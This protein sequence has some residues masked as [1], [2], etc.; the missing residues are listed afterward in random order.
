MEYIEPEIKENNPKKKYKKIILASCFGAVAV[1]GIALA[2]YFTIN[3][4]FLDYNNI[5]LFTYSY[6]YDEDNAGI[7]IDSIK[8][9]A[10]LPS[11]FRIPNKLNNRPVIEIAPEVFK[12][13]TELV[14][15]SF[16]SSLK[17]IGEQCFYGCENLESFNIP[18]NLES[19]GTEAF[20]N[21]KW[22]LDQE[23]GEVAIGSM[24]Y[25][26]KG[27]MDYPAY[28]IASDNV[29]STNGT[30]VDLRKY[31]NMSSGVFK[32][33]SNL[34]HVELPETFKEIYPSTFEGCEFLSEVVLHDGLEKIDSNAFYSC[35]NLSSIDIP[36]SVTYIGD[37]A[38]SYCAINGEI[39]L[40]SN[41]D[42]LGVG[43][44]DSCKQLETVNIPAGF[45]YISDYLFNGCEKLS[46]VNF[47]ESEYSANSKIDYIGAYAFYGTNI[48]EIHVPFNVTSIKQNAFANCK[49]LKNVYLYNNVDGTKK[50]S[51]ISAFE[52]EDGT[53]IEAGWVVEDGI[54]QGVENFEV[55]VFKDSP[56][57]DSII[58][59]DSNKTNVSNAGEISLPV[60]LKSLGGSNSEASLFTNTSITTLNLFKDFSGVTNEE[61][62]NKLQNDNSLRILP[63]S[64]CENARKLVNVNFGSE[65]TIETLGRNIFKNCTSLENIVIGNSVKTVETSAFEGCVN[66]KNVTLSTGSKTITE[67]TFAG[68]TSLKSIVIPDNYLTIGK[69]AFNGCTSLFEVKMSVNIN[70]IG[71]GAFA[72]CSALTNISIPDTCK[73]IAS[74]IFKNC[75][76][77]KDV[78]LPS[79]TNVRSVGNN[80]FEGDTALVNVTL[81]NN[82]Q[83]IGKEAFKSSGL[84]T[85]TIL[86][87]NGVVSLGDNAFENTNI[88]KILVPSSLVE[89]YKQ[90]SS[91]SI[92]SS[93]I[94]Q[95]D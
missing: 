70:D 23:D 54:Y 71:E 39:T 86:Y 31:V 74:S 66:L 89:Q 3:N 11:S 68:C 50:N 44:F 6:K 5:E 85:L 51:Y 28:V 45:K 91:W 19:I 87:E 34:I 15:V 95:I 1:T 65:S 24:L 33:Q 25:T 47:D 55:G 69:Y 61:Y 26:Y 22:L 53:V 12:D 40:N 18:E 4:I 72:N 13:R 56:K 37:Y 83:S 77:L 17:T 43:A 16:P 41:L 63:P 67:S 79:N 7:R 58:L 14:S 35:L 38:F 46:T 59:I 62:L 88:E 80:M 73:A 76:S 20:D 64:L 92:Y 30:V 2:Y 57:F 60:T 42:Y 52:D 81:S 78:T 9:D 36:E 75:V 29:S 8:D 93:I 82:Y 94:S 49:E 48:S 90:N 32:N 10:V 84:K 21:T 27:E